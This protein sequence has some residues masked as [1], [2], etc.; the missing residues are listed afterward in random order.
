MTCQKETLN[1][2]SGLYRDFLLSSNCCK[3]CEGAFRLPARTAER[4]LR[5]LRWAA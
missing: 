4:G 5:V 2:I 3:I 1:I